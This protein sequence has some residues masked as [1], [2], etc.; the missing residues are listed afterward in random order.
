[1]NSALLLRDIRWSSKNG[2]RETFSLPPYSCSNRPGLWNVLCACW[3]QDSFPSLRDSMVVGWQSPPQEVACLGKP[4]LFILVLRLHSPIQSYWGYPGPSARA[5][6]PNKPPVWAACWP[7]IPLLHVK[8]LS[9]PLMVPA[10]I[11]GSPSKITLQSLWRL[12]CHWSH[13]IQNSQGPASS[14]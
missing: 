1:M 3:A 8:P 14:T 6:L 13:S 5:T 11:S 7:E 4:S 2:K 9:P 12:N 10:K